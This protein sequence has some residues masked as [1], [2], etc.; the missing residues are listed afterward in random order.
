MQ[1]VLAQKD[2]LLANETK[3][4]ILKEF[5]QA[6]TLDF[7]YN[8]PVYRKLNFY[9]GTCLHIIYGLNRL[10]E[11]IDLDNSNGIDLGELKED[12]LT[13]YRTNSGYAEV[14]DNFSGHVTS[15]GIFHK[16]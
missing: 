13:F 15:R 14:V 7:L 5:L 4:V 12:L 9:G 2:P 6:Y 3:R 1:N 16:S 10:S 11:D 8:H